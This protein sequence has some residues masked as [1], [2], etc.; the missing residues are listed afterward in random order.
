[1]KKRKRKSSHQTRTVIIV[2][3]SLFAVAYFA[4]S[5]LPQATPLSINEVAVAP[6]TVILSLPATVSASSDTAVPITISTGGAQVS[7]AQIELTYDPA[8][9]SVSSVTMGNTLTVELAKPKISQGKITFTYATQ[10][11]SGGYDGEG[12]LATLTLRALSTSSTLSFTQDSMV[13]AVGFSSNML[14][15]VDNATIQIG[16]GATTP[17]TQPPVTQPS[18]RVFNEQGNFNYAKTAI[19]PTVSV[20]ETPPS[21]SF[22]ARFLAWIKALFEK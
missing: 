19:I 16:Q 3:L 17:T 5:R 9:I 20:T 18:D 22:F 15:S 14:K 12:T 8:A 2:V 13:A 10:P 6:A 7:A 21:S 1:M 4:I 11:D